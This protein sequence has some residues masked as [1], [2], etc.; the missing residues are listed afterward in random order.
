MIGWRSSP[1]VLISHLLP[2][3]SGQPVGNDIWIAFAWCDGIM[4]VGYIFTMR[5]IKAGVKE[6]FVKGLTYSEK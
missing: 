2:L 4:L 6:L 1:L 5:R 3:L